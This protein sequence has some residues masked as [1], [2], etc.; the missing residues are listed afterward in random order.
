VMKDT[1]SGFEAQDYC[2]TVING[3]L[4]KIYMDEIEKIKD[5]FALDRIFLEMCWTQNLDTPP[6]QKIEDPEAFKNIEHP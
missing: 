5:S 6:Y 1:K 3:V 4:N 2:K